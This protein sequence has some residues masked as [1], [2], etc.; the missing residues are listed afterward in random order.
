M[1]PKLAVISDCLQAEEYTLCLPRMTCMMESHKLLSAQTLWMHL[2]AQGLHCLQGSCPR[3]MSVVITFRKY[4]G[5]SD[6]V[7]TWFYVFVPVLYGKK[8]SFYLNRWKLNAGWSRGG[9]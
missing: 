5:C 2:T 4:L 7:L 9:L 8:H 6:S 1:E 3:N